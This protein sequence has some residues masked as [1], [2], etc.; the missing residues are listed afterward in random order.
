MVD[1]RF[2]R[3]SCPRRTRSSERGALRLR[4]T[5][6]LDLR[7]VNDTQVT[8]RADSQLRPQGVES[9]D[10]GFDIRWPVGMMF[11]VF[12]L[13]IGDTACRPR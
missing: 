12:G 4:P 8:A 11:S 5:A 10:M 6:S 2:I 1:I 3:C 13:L 9:E 7:Q